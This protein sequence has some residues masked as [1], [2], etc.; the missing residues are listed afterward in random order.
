[1]ESSLLTPMDLH[2]LARS[3]ERLA[4]Q[5]NLPCGDRVSGRPREGPG[6]QPGYP[7]ASVAAPNGAKKEMMMGGSEASSTKPK[8]A[9]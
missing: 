7:F 9:W 4:H 6:S 1:M 8:K 2:R 5:G 3:L